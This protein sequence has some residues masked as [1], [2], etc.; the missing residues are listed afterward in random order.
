MKQTTTISVEHVVVSSTRA[1]EQ[2][3]A[4]LDARL[5][6]LENPDE[7]VR[8]WTLACA[9]WA[10]IKQAIEKKLGTSGFGVFSKVEQGRLLAFS[11]GKLVHACQ[12]AV[13][14][15]LLAIQMIA[16]VPEVALY[17]PLRLTVYTIDGN[18]KTFIAYD[19]FTS[20]L[21]QY[22]RAEISTVS[23]LVERRLEKLVDEAA[24]DLGV[25]SDVADVTSAG[26]DYRPRRIL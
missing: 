9:S 25:E 2:V 20:M 19:R 13:G 4:S 8:E 18:D 17:A 16:Q 22:Q 10:D 7:L 12:Y 5:G 21:A 26:T 1:Y 14:N 6:D 24:A 11:T 15:P 3:I 23:Q